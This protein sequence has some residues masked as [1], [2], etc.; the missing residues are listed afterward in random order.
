MIQYHII[1]YPYSVSLMHTL[2]Y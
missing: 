2:F 1:I